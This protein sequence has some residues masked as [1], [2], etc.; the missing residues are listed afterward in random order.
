M[1]LS[2]WQE[3]I[4]QDFIVL[5]ISNQSIPEIQQFIED[6]GITFPVLHDD[7]NVYHD[8]NLPGGQSP[9]PR[10]FVVD[11]Q[12]I[13]Q[14]ASAEYDPGSMIMIIES[15]LYSEPEPRT[16]LTELFG[17]TWCFSCSLA[18]EAVDSLVQEFGPDSLIILEYHWFDGLAIPEGEDRARWY[19]P[20]PFNIPNMWFD[21]T[22]NVVGA[23]SGTYDTYRNHI[24][25]RLEEPSPLKLDYS[26]KMT[27]VVTIM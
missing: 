2:I 25:D 11:Q 17:A 14:Y 8:Y 9:Y 26:S 19:V 16:V 3:F 27:W 5:G 24:L 21:G 15:L 10:D 23:N 22:I 18:S 13:L 20:G 7:A 4:D 12:G 1:E 6:Q